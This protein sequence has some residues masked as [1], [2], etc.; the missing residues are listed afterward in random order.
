V[1]ACK[2]RRRRRIRCV[3][4]V[5]ASGRVDHDGCTAEQG[6]TEATAQCNK[7]TWALHGECV[8]VRALDGAASGFMLHIG[9]YWGLRLSGELEYIL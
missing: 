6:I 7:I 4:T 8:R 1:V 3:F 9:S 5:S 2:K